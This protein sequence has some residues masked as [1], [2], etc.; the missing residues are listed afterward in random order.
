[1]STMSPIQSEACLLLSLPNA[2]LTSANGRTYSGVLNLECVAVALQNTVSSDSNV[3]LIIRLD[4]FETALDPTKPISLNVVPDG[5]RTYTFHDSIIPDIGG[6]H[7]LVLRLSSKA[8]VP[9]AETFDGILGQYADNFYAADIL[10][11]RSAPSTQASQAISVDRKDEDLRGHL[12]LVD[13]DNGQVLGA[14]D[15]KL[16]VHEDPS[17]HE[18][19]ENEPVVIEVPEDEDLDTLGAHEVFVRAIPPEEHNWMTKGASYLSQA[20]TAGT[21]LLLTGVTR[22][23]DYYVAHS[24]PYTPTSSGDNAAAS[25]S[26]DGAGSSGSPKS[27]P[28]ALLTSERT[29]K[30]LAQVHAISGQAVKV[31]QKTVGIVEGMVKRVVGG[32]PVNS[33][34]SNA[35]PALPPRKTIPAPFASGS[36]P[37]PYTPYQPSSASF[38]LS[39]YGEKPPLPARR[40]PS[41]AP[42]V[43]ASVVTPTTE[44]PTTPKKF[45]TGDRLALSADLI[46]STIDDSTKRIFDVGSDS[47]A[48]VADHKYGSEAGHNTRLLMHTGR[49]V[50]LVYIDMRGFGRRALV[51]KAG[52][53]YVKSRVRLKKPE[54]NKS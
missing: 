50:A 45:S 43:S 38:S 33:A 10:E 34:L 19:G 27:M 18:R 29:R 9:D 4:E 21:A 35:R 8:A 49:N 13:E 5:S 30:G 46:L 16:K 53:E 32:S 3:Y 26:K 6:T 1:M 42:P 36:A 48:K 14:L 47:L 11:S 28:L 2:T 31:S 20:I 22:A 15:T 17:L 52:K 40:S 41:L 24:S 44:E 23:S 25:T 39:A 51:K 54:H 12:V 7:D 37:P